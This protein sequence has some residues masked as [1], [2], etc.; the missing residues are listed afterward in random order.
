MENDKLGNMVD[1]IKAAAE[2]LEIKLHENS[3]DG[4]KEFVATFNPTYPTDSIKLIDAANMIFSHKSFPGSIEKAILQEALIQ[5]DFV[6]GD[7]GWKLTDKGSL[8]VGFTPKK[9]AAY[10]EISFGDLTFPLTVHVDRYCDMDDL[11]NHHEGCPM[12][13][14]EDDPEYS[15]DCNCE[16]WTEASFEKTFNDTEDLKE[17]GT[18]LLRARW[19]AQ[20]GK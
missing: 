15:D 11:I 5:G 3:F 20:E 7:F 17:L 16:S 10:Y 14:S 9:T 8:S 13:L 1:K 18:F 4:L 2:A 19:S 12:L 6:S